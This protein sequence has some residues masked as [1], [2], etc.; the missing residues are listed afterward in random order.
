MVRLKTWELLISSGTLLPSTFP[1]ASVLLEVEVCSP[2][3]KIKMLVIIWYAKIDI[4]CYLVALLVDD[5]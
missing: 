1:A 2:A 3:K 5:P 4:V